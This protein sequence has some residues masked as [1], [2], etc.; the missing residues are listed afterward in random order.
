MR[1][2]YPR[3]A[4]AALLPRMVPPPPSTSIPCQGNYTDEQEDARK[5]GKD[6]GLRHR[7]SHAHYEQQKR[8]C[9][10]VPLVAVDPENSTQQPLPRKML[11]RCL[12]GDTHGRKGSVIWRACE[13]TIR[14]SVP[15]GSVYTIG[16]LTRGRTHS[17]SADR[18]VRRQR[19]R[20]S[21]T[22]PT[23]RYRIAHRS[24][25]DRARCRPPAPV[26]DR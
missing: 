16:L 23:P 2:L 13:R 12:L 11:Y 17:N 6:R 4:A 19:D 20:H 8:V 3:S 25:T 26:T 1:L 5:H 14:Q 18:P 21:W 15:V 9:Q 24:R 7:R 10:V 22:A